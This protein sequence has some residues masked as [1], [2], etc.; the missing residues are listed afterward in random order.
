MNRRKFFSFLPVA[1]V[2]IVMAATAEAKAPCASLAPEKELM[3]LK[4]YK[5]PPPPPPPKPQSFGL[6]RYCTSINTGY[7]TLGY[8]TDTSL[9]VGTGFDVKSGPDF[10]EETKVSM[11]VGKDGHLWLKIGDA[12]KRVVTE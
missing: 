4:A 5:P 6:T 1:P 7:T 8:P 9:K 11:A 10:D 2:G 12:W 3:T